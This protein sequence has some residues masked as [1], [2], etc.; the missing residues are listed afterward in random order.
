MSWTPGQTVVVS[1]SRRT[2]RVERVA[3]SSG[4]L[5]SAGDAV[6][7]TFADGIDLAFAGIVSQF[8]TAGRL[9]RTG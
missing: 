6:T 7:L 4:D 2:T 9:I 8:A 5:A 1:G 3:R